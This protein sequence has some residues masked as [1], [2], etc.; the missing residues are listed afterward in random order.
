MLSSL[1]LHHD[2][3][4]RITE[5]THQS[6]TYTLVSNNCS[7]L[8]SDSCSPVTVCSRCAQCSTEQS[9]QSVCTVQH[10]A[11]LPVGV[12]SA[13]QSSPV[14]PPTAQSPVLQHAFRATRCPQVQEPELKRNF[15]RPLWQCFR[16]RIVNKVGSDPSLLVSHVR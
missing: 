4:W 5:Q 7:N 15:S 3:I 8:H 14:A 11:V 9:C 13:A 6:V 1:S 12:H 16:Y 10:I 2:G